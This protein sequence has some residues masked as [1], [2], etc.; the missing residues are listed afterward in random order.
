M[1]YLLS[2]QYQYY[3]VCVEILYSRINM[4]ISGYYD[5]ADGHSAYGVS[6]E[7]D[8]SVLS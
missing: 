2:M 8:V 4:I 1:E 6:S 5:F 3:H 7:Y